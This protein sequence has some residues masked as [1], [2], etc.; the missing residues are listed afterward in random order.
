[1]GLR[2]PEVRMSVRILQ[3]VRE[4]SEKPARDQMDFLRTSRKV[5]KS[6][7]LRPD[8]WSTVIRES[9][10]KRTNGS[11]FTWMETPEVVLRV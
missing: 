8:E 11:K 10:K 1:M 5:K 4:D 7:I 2:V 9:S 3:P 6:S